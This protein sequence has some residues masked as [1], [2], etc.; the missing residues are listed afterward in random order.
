MSDN[1][2]SPSRSPRN[3]DLGLI[4]R[5]ILTAL[6]SQREKLEGRLLDV[7]CGQMPYKKILLESGGGRVTEYIG[8]D[9]ANNPIHQNQPDI[10]WDEGKIPLASNSV[11]SA[12]LT[13]VLE[14]VPNPTELLTEIL[15]VMKPGAV[16]FLTVPYLWPLHEVPYD[17]YRY[18]PFALTRH[19]Q[20]AGFSNVELHATGGWDASLAQMLGL[21]VKRGPLG[22]I[23]RR[24][25][26]VFIFP[27]Y[28]WLLHRDRK[29][30]VVEFKEGTMLTGL[31][32]TAVKASTDQSGKQS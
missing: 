32:G 24:L 14:H 17:N 9:L 22:R 18:T 8:L 11:D 1:F 21:W 10:L 5:S 19:L 6:L 23:Q 27:L 3:I 20:E 12:L 31:W 16:L 30:P 25:L 4:R 29:R 2:L 15:R 26:A 13:E 28:L 7:G